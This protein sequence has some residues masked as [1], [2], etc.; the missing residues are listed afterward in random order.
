MKQYLLIA[1]A[2]L[3]VL[4][5]LTSCNKPSGDPEKDAEAFQGLFEEQQK[6]ELEAQQKIADLA[7]Y[8][9]ENKDY[10][11]YQE[12]QDEFLDITKDLQDKYEDQVKDLEKSIAKLEK[13]INKKNKNNDDEEESYD[14]EDEE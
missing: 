13:K 6:I 5:V 11:A 10:D 7:E 14:E 8:Y 1:A 2:V 9:A 12:L 4:P 3:L